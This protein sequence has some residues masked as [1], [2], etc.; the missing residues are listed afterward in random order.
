MLALDISALPHWYNHP[1]IIVVATSLIYRRAH[2]HRKLE[3]NHDS[4]IYTYRYSNQ[5]L[6]GFDAATKVASSGQSM[7]YRLL[8]GKGIKNIHIWYSLSLHLDPD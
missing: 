8:C 2:E 4:L 6:R 3:K 7:E 5:K 1:Y